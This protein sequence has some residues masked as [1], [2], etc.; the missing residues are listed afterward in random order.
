MESSSDWDLQTAKLT[1]NKRWVE[2]EEDEY[3]C[4]VVLL[5][6]AGER[7][8]SSAVNMMCN[9]EVLTLLNKQSCRPPTSVGSIFTPTR[10]D[11]QCKRTGVGSIKEL[12]RPSL[13]WT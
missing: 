6:M 9:Y 3:S 2:E 4:P 5:M 8:V 12:S 11:V 10:S 7:K 13:S 1:Y